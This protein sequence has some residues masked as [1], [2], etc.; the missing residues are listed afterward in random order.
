MLT[1]KEKD[2]VLHFYQREILYL[3]SVSILK[4]L[5]CE[6]LLSGNEQLNQQTHEREIRLGFSLDK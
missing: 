6:L 3:K 4:A 5:L 2:G 1:E